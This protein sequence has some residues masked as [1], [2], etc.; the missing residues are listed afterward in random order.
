[1]QAEFVRRT[2]KGGV[3]VISDVVPQG[4]DVGAGLGIVLDA[5]VS[6]AGWILSAGA[7]ALVC[8]ASSTVWWRRRA[9]RELAARRRFAMVPAVTFD[10]QLADVGQAAARLSEARAAAGPIPE[11]AAAMRVWV[12]A[13]QESRLSYGWEGP[14]RAA[15]VLRL[16]GYRQVEVLAAEAARDC[17][18]RVRFEGVDPLT[19][20]GGW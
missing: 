13:G 17:S 12:T 7:I 4:L 9:V 3:V 20:G 14:E 5:A 19:E 16:P 6:H 1:M 8:W 15:S 2:V 10:P 18:A 11:R